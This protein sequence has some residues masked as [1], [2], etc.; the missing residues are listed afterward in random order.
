MADFVLN[1]NN[2]IIQQLMK[3]DNSQINIHIEQAVGS[4]GGD[5]ASWSTVALYGITIVL[6]IFTGIYYMTVENEDIFRWKNRTSII[7][8]LIFCNLAYFIVIV[9][10]AIIPKNR[11]DLRSPIY[12]VV[13]FIFFSIVLKNK[14]RIV[15]IYGICSGLIYV[16]LELFL[17]EPHNYSVVF[18]CIILIFS[19][20]FFYMAI[21]KEK[22]CPLK[23]YLFYLVDQK[24]YSAK[25]ESITE[26][27]LVLRDV[28]LYNRKVSKRSIYKPENKSFDIK[29]IQNISSEKKILEKT[30]IIPR[31]QVLAM[32]VI[33]EKNKIK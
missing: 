18:F 27:F 26:G 33:D 21:N 5:L 2:F 12:I 29:R 3:G 25:L 17:F 22:L 4:L 24:C 28:E 23:E 13:V 32:Y 20:T 10:D 16:L 8:Q 11:S 31:E 30:M 15:A 19:L 9:L 1:L 6:M 14:S 7:A